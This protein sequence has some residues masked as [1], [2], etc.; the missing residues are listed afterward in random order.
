VWKDKTFHQ[1][2]TVCF[3]IVS[4]QALQWREVFYAAKILAKDRSFAIENLKYYVILHFN[5]CV[6]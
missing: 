6:W 4:T 5:A 3:S 2:F 1:L